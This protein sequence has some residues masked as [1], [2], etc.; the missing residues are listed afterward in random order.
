MVTTATTMARLGRPRHSEQHRSRRHLLRNDDS[1]LP[2]PFPHLP[3]LL[4][5]FMVRVR[6]SSSSSIGIIIG[7]TI[8]VSGDVTMEVEGA[9]RKGARVMAQPLL[10]ALIRVLVPSAGPCEGLAQLLALLVPLKEEQR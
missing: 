1:E 5:L 6:S 7:I 8:V 2:L 4:T 9:P 3:L 10:L